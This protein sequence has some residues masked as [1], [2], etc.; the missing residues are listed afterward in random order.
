MDNMAARTHVLTD[1]F[2]V[3][4]VVFLKLLIFWLVTQS[5]SPG[6]SKSWFY[7]GSY[8]YRMFLSVLMQ[9]YC[10]QE[11]VLSHEEGRSPVDDA[12]LEGHLGVTRELLL[13]QPAPKKYA[14][15]SQKDGYNLI[16]VNITCICLHWEVISLFQCHLM[17]WF[18]IFIET[19]W[20]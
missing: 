1:V 3:V 12:L 4:A 14:I 5:S 19:Y 10:F 2:V 16:K 8:W 17:L 20:F 11:L 15:G 13:F 6:Q 7:G 18:A 9:W